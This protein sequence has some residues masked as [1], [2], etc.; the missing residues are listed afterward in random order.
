MRTLLLTIA[1]SAIA[2]PAPAQ[3][4]P[5][6][7]WT[8]G[9]LAVDRD[10][11]YR[12]LDESLLFAPLVRFEGERTYLRGL[13]GGLR[14]YD[15]ER[16]EVA[17]FAQARLDGYD[18]E[19]S[20]FLAGMADRR[21]SLDLGIASTW[22]VK[23][24]GAFELSLAADALDRSGGIEA[25]ASWNGLFRAGAWTVVP[26]ASVRWQNAGLVDY[27]YGVRSGEAL[28]GR[29]AYAADAA[30]TPDVSL[31]VARPF[32]GRW[33]LFARASHTWLPPEI[34]RSPLVA[35]NARTA[36]FLGVGYSPD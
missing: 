16:V 22:K 4:Q 17:V 31:L 20:T 13:R 12:G 34:T 7:R 27:Y 26:G 6:P 10:A 19:D 24:I 2:T 36:L 18:A 15:T 11:P 33:T 28:P 23:K 14:L 29:P 32:A 5:P 30:V 35:R 9:L 25:A 1:L 8:F 3:P 21:A